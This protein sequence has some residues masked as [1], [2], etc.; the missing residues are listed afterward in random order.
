M[1]N[2]ALPQSC[3]ISKRELGARVGETPGWVTKQL[4]QILEDP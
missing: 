1:L 3:G 4:V 2:P